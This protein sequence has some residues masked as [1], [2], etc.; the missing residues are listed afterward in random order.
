M[1]DFG[2]VFSVSCTFLFCR[3]YM[4]GLAGV[5]ALLQVVTI[6]QSYQNDLRRKKSNT[7]NQFTNKSSFN[8]KT[9]CHVSFWMVGREQWEWCLSF[10]CPLLSF[11]HIVIVIELLPF[12]SSLV[13]SSCPSPHGGCWVRCFFF[14]NRIYKVSKVGFHKELQI[15]WET[16]DF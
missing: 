12:S 15:I 1:A 10:S 4:L 5:P 16:G 3:R 14:W 8:R 11:Y 6:L 9:C 13:F 7:F 2:N